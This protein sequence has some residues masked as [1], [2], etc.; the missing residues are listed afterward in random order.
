MSKMCR[1]FVDENAATKTDGLRY[2]QQESGSCRY[3]VSHNATAYSVACWQRHLGRFIGGWSLELSSPCECCVQMVFRQNLIFNGF[4]T[5][6]LLKFFWLKFD[7]RQH[8]LWPCLFG[9]ASACTLMGVFL[10][11]GW[12]QIPQNNSVSVI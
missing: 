7:T 9:N 6:L 2:G 1:L 8:H 3:H 12:V 10:G 4:N 5:Y 11:C